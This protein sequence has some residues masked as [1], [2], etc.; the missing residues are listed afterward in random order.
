MAGLKMLRRFT[1]LC[2]ISEIIC[3]L[4][5]WG[6]NGKAV[7]EIYPSRAFTQCTIL[8]TK[9]YVHYTTSALP[10]NRPLA[11]Y[12]AISR[13]FGHP[14]QASTLST[15]FLTLATVFFGAAC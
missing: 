13:S 4:L 8:N 15:I 2:E 9:M 7:M 12:S 10:G 6:R 1:R 5:H 3:T 14:P 11:Q